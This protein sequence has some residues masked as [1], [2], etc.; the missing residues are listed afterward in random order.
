MKNKQG[1]TIHR[2]YQLLPNS[3]IRLIAYTQLDIFSNQSLIYQP[4]W[5]GLFSYLFA[6]K[7]R[8]VL[9]VFTLQ[10]FM[11][12]V[13][14][15]HYF[16]TISRAA[17]AFHPV[18]IIINHGIINSQFL[19]SFNVA[20][21][22]KGYFSAHSYIWI[23]R[24]IKKHHYFLNFTFHKRREN[25]IVVNLQ[26]RGTY[27]FF[28]FL[29]GFP[30]NN[31]AALNCYNFSFSDWFYRK[32]AATF[33]P[34]F[35]RFLGLRRNIGGYVHKVK[36]FLFPKLKCSSSRYFYRF[37][38]SFYRRGGAAISEFRGGPSSPPLAAKT[39]RTISRI[40]HILEKD[41]ELEAASLRS[42][43]NWY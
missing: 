25:K 11:L 32:Q 28:V 13:L 24:M 17:I 4:Y 35:Y 23:A 26:V 20:H 18:V 42:A 30:I 8:E 40:D 36:N 12:P 19:A 1:L 14:A 27:Q 31:M 6:E 2:F 15:C 22:N 16:T 9:A 37:F 43:V 5:F 38:G 3:S 41:K 10:I 33:Y 34:T 39:F 21:R 29:E 7:K